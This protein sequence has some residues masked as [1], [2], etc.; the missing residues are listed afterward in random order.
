MTTPTRLTDNRVFRAMT[1]QDADALFREIALLTVKI[2]KIE[3]GYEKKIADL[4]AAANRE[5][6]ELEDELRWKVARLTSYIQANPERFIKPRQHATDYGKYGVRTVSNLEITDE[7]AVKLAVKAHGIP[8]LIVT[9]KL[10][11]KALEKAIG[12]G[13][14]IRGCEL[15]RG[16]IASYTVAKALM[17]E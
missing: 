16:E 10:D 15:R 11:K 9:E 14:E 1:V 4:K 12:D 5:T 2:G 7:E 3:A 6:E 17:E 8:A 13:Q